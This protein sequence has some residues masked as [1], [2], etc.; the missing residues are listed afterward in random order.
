MVLL[1]VEDVRDWL[2]PAGNL[3]EGLGALGRA[4]VVMVRE[5]EAD[6]LA[7]VIAARTK[8][9]VW[10]VR[11]ELVLAVEMPKRVVVFCGIARPEGFLGMLR[12]AGVQVVG[13]VVKGDHHAYTAEDVSLLV[14]AGRRVGADGFVTTGKDAVKISA[15]WLGRLEEVGPV[16]VA[17]LRVSLLD[18]VGVW[19]RVRRACG[20]G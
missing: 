20:W 10:V 6:S 9:E 5:E 4:D 7:E 3:R 17:G 18:E 1:T 14:E 11:R 19:E 13:R 12:E 8:A 15:E 16:V 2:L